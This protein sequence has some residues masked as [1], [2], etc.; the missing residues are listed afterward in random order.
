MKHHSALTISMLLVLHAQAFGQASKE[1]SSSNKTDV[2]EDSAKLPAAADSY[3]VAVWK[4]SPA[5][6]SKPAL[7]YRFWPHASQ[8]KPGK[9]QLYYFRAVAA[10]QQAE[11]ALRAILAIAQQD[12]YV[13]EEVRIF[14]Q[15]ITPVFDNLERMAFCEDTS[16][17]RRRH[18]AT[19]AKLL[20][21]GVDDLQ[22]AR[23]LVR[24]LVYKAAVQRA[25]RDFDGVSRT[26][27][28]GNRLAYLLGRGES[29]IQRAI[30]C[31]LSAQM[32]IVIQETIQTPGCPNLYW[33]IATMPQPL[34]QSR[35]AIELNLH[36]INTVFPELR[37]ARTADWPEDTS[38]E[39]W[40]ACLA[41]LTG[42]YGPQEAQT[43]WIH[44]A[45]DCSKFVG[46]ARARLLAKGHSTERLNSM[47]ATS[48]VMADV[49]YELDRLNEEI[50]KIILLPWGQRRWVQQ[51]H[52]VGFAEVASYS[53]ERE[54][55]ELPQ[56]AVTLFASFIVP[57]IRQ[58]E[59]LV[60]RSPVML[61]RLMTLE[62]IRQYAA[63]NEGQIPQ[64][65]NDVNLLPVVNAFGSEA[66]FEYSVELS[67]EGPI[68]ILSGE[69]PGYP[70]ATEL[71][72]RVTND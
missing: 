71:K 25:D 7:R 59:E 24:L 16:W 3:E 8:L 51:M 14:L 63:A 4:V 10:I 32:R 48:I 57:S 35:P 39:K 54:S 15:S 65:L 45:K 42:V 58:L 18:D 69:I 55:A 1:L 5:A 19:G 44:N 38:L 43:R 22:L 50:T 17:D 70:A 29:V 2:S 12:D 34:I 33:A 13:T 61:R 23:D 20:G 21:L 9:A 53:D 36:A 68:G 72:F 64:S 47:P 26:V 46:R 31:A 41:R 30:A 49:A 67:D 52:N 66:P 6:D 37:E 62:A 60:H 40:E 28:I 56:S 11:G 27:L